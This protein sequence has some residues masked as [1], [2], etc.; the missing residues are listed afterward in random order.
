MMLAVYS[1]FIVSCSQNK[2][3]HKH[4]HNHQEQAEEGHDHEDGHM[5]EH[6]EHGEERH[7]HNCGQ[8]HDE[9]HEQ[10]AIPG[11]IAFTKAQASR[12]NFSIE[13]PR[14]EPLGQVIRTTARIASDQ[15]DETIIAA[16]TSGIVVLAG[17]PVAEGKIVNPG[18]VLFY[19]S[20]SG[21]ADN[22][23]SV[24]LAE[25]Q[26]SFI[27][28]ES[29]YNRAQDLAQDKIVPEKQLQQSKSEYESAKALYESLYKNFSEKGQRVSSPSSGF[30]RQVFVSNGQ[31]VET[32]QPL[33]SVSK[34]KSLLLKADVPARYA[35]LLPLIYT[36]NIRKPNNPETYSLSD[37][38][39]KILSFGRAVNE[40]NLMI[41]VNFQIDNKAG[42]IPGGFIE[43]FIKT[44][45]EKPVLSVPQEAIIESQGVYFVFVEAAP[46]QYQKRQVKTGIS[47]G[48]RTEIISGITENESVVGRGAVSVKLAEASGSLDPHAG[49]AH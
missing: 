21:M 23:L 33:I 12:I 17:S 13:K 44:K 4:E 30:I 8:K 5:H 7:S 24:K 39:G 28:A 22:N 47:D 48:I 46:E 43:L 15:A 37:L 16:R 11:A 2:Q 3:E 36:A 18:Q 10:E 42:F 34:N 14:Y 32:G 1:L 45:S 26:S 29:D 20:G 40:D 6:A 35:S 27:K 38:N 25:A 19:V 31:Y 49:H 9:E 41:P